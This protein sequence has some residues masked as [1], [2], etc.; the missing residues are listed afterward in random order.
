MFV[1]TFYLFFLLKQ[2]DYKSE[3]ALP[4]GRRLTDKHLKGPMQVLVVKF[5]I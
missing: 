1:T 5:T 4:N 2:T 3:G